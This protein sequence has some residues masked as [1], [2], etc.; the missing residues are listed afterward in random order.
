MTI[1]APLSIAPIGRDTLLEEALEYGVLCP[2]CRA[3]MVP[4]TTTL[5]WWDCINPLCI[6]GE[7]PG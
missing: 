2:A 7:Q 4:A 1:N 3:L 6:S 5:S